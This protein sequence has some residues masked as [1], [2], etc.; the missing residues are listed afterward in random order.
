MALDVKGKMAGALAGW[1]AR[2]AGSGVASVY[3]MVSAAALWPMAQAAARGDVATMIGFG[4][5]LGG[6]VGANL[7]ANQ[8]QRWQDEADAARQ[9]AAL[10]I[11]DPARAELDAV[12]EKFEVIALAL[13]ALPPGDRSWFQ[14][15]L[16]EELARLGN[17]DRFQIQI[18]GEGNVAVQGNGN[19]VA[20]TRGDG[21]VTV[22]G[23]R[24]DVLG[25]GAKKITQ[26]GKKNILMTG[27]GAVVIDGGIAAGQGGLAVGGNVKAVHIH[28][29]QPAPPAIP[30][31]AAGKNSLE[32]YLQWLINECAPLRLNLIQEGGA[33]PGKKPLGLASVYVDLN[34]DLR[35]P[36]KVS[37][38]DYLARQVQGDERQRSVLG[39]SEKPRDPEKVGAPEKGTRL[40]A[41]LEALGSLRAH[42]A[43]V[44]LGAPGTG[45]STLVAYVAMSLAQAALHEQGA[46]GRLGPWWQ[47]GA[48]IPVRVVLRHFAA[49]LP[50][51]LDHGRA[52]H[53][54]DFIRAEMVKSGLG[55]GTADALCEVAQG[56]GALFLLDGLDE[57]REES[58]RARVL[59]AVDEFTRSAGAQCR[60]L[61]TSRPYAWSEMVDTKA[62]PARLA[63]RCAAYQLA[64]FQSDQIQQFIEHW[65]AAIGALG[66]V[67]AADAR[68]KTQDLIGA[69]RRPD[70]E[71]LARNP[72]LLTLMATLHSN[73]TRLPDDRADLYD[74]VVGLL[75][76]RWNETA[77]ADRGLLAALA[78]PTLKL[79]DLREVL[80][81]LA[82]E[83][84]A[85]QD[86][87][88]GLADIPEGELLA[89]LRPLLG[90]DIAKADKAL[91]YIENRAGLLL[92]QGPRGRQ[93]Q[94]TFPHRT[95][96]EYLAACH[97]AG[98]ADFCQQAARLAHDQPG[99][100]REV[101]ALA[102]RQAR[103]DRGVPAA[104]TLIYAQGL[105]LW[106]MTQPPTDADWRAAILAGEQLLEI[107]LAAVESRHEHRAVRERVAGW[108]AALVAEGQLPPTE[109]ARAGMVLGKL[110]DP[111]PG[112][113]LRPDGLPDIDWIEIAPGL[114]PM[115]NDKPEARCND[116]TP[117][118]VCSLIKKP[119]AISRYPITVA[120]YA[121]FV[122]AG[123]YGHE[124]YWTKDGWRWRQKDGVSGPR[125][126]SEFDRIPNHPRVGVS[127]YEAAAYCRW[128]G[129]QLQLPVR[130]PSEAEWER[131]AR[132]T[133]ARN[134]PWGN[135]DSD[136]AQRCNVYETVIGHTSAVGMFP[137]GAAV[138]G[139]SDMAGNVWEW[140]GTKLLSDYQGYETR[141]SDALEGSDARVLRGGAF[142]YLRGGARCSSRYR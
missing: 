21:N 62:L 52:H 86:G 72:L 60:Y 93:R 97:L 58:A 2:L 79:G 141:A 134:Y 53:L 14:Q 16:R 113:G 37:L 98:R 26:R 29:H 92:G 88:E 59:E 34:V 124:E 28:N 91:E 1:K 135:E 41:A 130:L 80:A 78:V 40:V 89:A 81:R 139:A 83:A 110:G 138:C 99:H 30:Q 94:Y 65:Y 4:A 48:L 69:V 31:A 50:A 8:L 136:V 122:A 74:A 19:Q 102:A 95:F 120:Q 5:A 6:S 117:R 103:P 27:P 133:D 121:A 82:F 61:L 127:W 111:R 13:A 115:G 46:I 55:T 129:E 18:T 24:N 87:D 107:G 77:G 96:Q 39:R 11:G 101:L 66:W 75:L 35:L 20:Q 43:L 109:R 51:G 90:N 36:M 116:E 54:W 45:K 123:G 73:R 131:A 106:R 67:G 12:I 119:Y 15:T 7:L 128:L 84:H 70:L 126:Y 125:D 118:F 32:S 38:V 64:D 22:Q 137:D 132:H 104:D 76:E 100:W 17:L 114:F 33:G 25:K 3:A 44:L 108:L 9:L 68:Q 71:V 112:V 42:D 105:A 49:S 47:S 142:Y 23:S 85:G 63:E 56:R 10:P 57:A 140:C